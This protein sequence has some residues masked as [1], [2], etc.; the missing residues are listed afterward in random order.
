MGAFDYDLTWFGNGDWANYT[1]VYP[2]GNFYVYGRFSGLGGYSMYLDQVVSGAGTTS[3]VTTRLGR[4]GIV[5]RG[6]NIYDW[7]PLTDEGLAAPVRGKAERS[8]HA[9]DRNHR[10]QQSKLFHAGASDRHHLDG[11]ALGRTM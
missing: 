1:R 10:Q 5:G 2:S 9:A 6:Y 11:R 7:V 4:W 3:Q 8:Q